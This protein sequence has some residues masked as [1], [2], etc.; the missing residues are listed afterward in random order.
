[1]MLGSVSAAK[2]WQLED[3]L[4]GEHATP[5]RANSWRYRRDGAPRALALAGIAAGLVAL[6]V[7][8]L[9]ALRSYRRWRDAATLQPTAAWALGVLGIGLIPVLVLALATPLIGLAV[10]V[11]LAGIPAA[12]VITLRG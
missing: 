2:L 3:S 1:M 9:V 8:G 10:L 4:T 11:G 12:L 6:I 7:P 5:P